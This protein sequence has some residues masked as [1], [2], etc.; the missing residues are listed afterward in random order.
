[1]GLS[2]SYGIINRHHGTIIV[3]SVEGEGSTFTIRFP[4]T[5]KIGKG[6]V[7]EEKVISIKKKQK[8][9]ILVIEDEEDVRK[10]LRDILTDAGHKVDVANDGSEGIEIFKKKKFD[11]VLTDLGMPR[12]SGWEVAE[13]VKSINGKVPVA[14]ITGWNIALDSSEMKDSGIN[15][16]IHKPFKMEQILNLVQEGMVLKDQIK[17][18]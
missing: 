5:K 1:L 9:R 12:M 2:V 15:L 17:A 10:L 14:L 6:N 18:V 3:N 16:V 7:K 11:L 8:A 13:K 4:I